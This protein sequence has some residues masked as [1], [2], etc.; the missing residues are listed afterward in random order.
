MDRRNLF[1]GALAGALGFVASRQLVGAEVVPGGLVEFEASEDWVQVL[2]D[3]H[4]NGVYEFGFG[5]TD[6]GARFLPV[7]GYGWQEMTGTGMLLPE[8]APEDLLSDQIIRRTF[9]ARAVR[10]NY[11]EQEVVTGPDAYGNW[12]VPDF[13]GMAGGTL[14]GPDQFGNWF[15]PYQR[16]VRDEERVLVRDHGVLAGSP[17]PF[18][19]RWDWVVG[20]WV[21]N[22]ERWT[23]AQVVSPIERVRLATSILDA[24][25]LA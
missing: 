21:L 20:H 14:T 15:V 1:K 11:V 4:I 6:G 13:S 16:S 8:N 7:P 10:K 9:L 23:E 25:E 2:P 19:F 22:R 17:D 5:D 18:L 12:Y 24:A 3:P